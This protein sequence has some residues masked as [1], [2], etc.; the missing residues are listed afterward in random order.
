MVGLFREHWVAPAVIALGITL[1][2]S[3]KLGMYQRTMIYKGEDVKKWD[4]REINMTEAVCLV[5]LALLV[6]WLGLFP[7]TFIDYISPTT[8]RIVELANTTRSSQSAD[9]TLDKHSLRNP[10]NSVLP[11]KVSDDVNKKGTIFNSLEAAT[12]MVKPIIIESSDSLQTA[13][14]YLKKDSDKKGF[15]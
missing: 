13:K 9:K 5:P 7:G 6:L 15:K 14:Y 8:K 10:S 1:G 11:L 4:S 12:S 2:I 3:Y